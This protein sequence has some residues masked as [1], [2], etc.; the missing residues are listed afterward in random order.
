MDQGGSSENQYHE[1]GN[2]GVILASGLWSS[3]LWIK[4]LDKK[5][6]SDHGATGNEYTDHFMQPFNN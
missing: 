2:Q 3:I 6:Y 4:S 1:N 5:R